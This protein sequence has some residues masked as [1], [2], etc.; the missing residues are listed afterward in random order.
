MLHWEFDVIVALENSKP[1][2][3][4]DTKD[5]RTCSGVHMSLQ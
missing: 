5:D 1:Q 2:H 4:N 3:C